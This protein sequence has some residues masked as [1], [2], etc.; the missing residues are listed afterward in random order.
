MSRGEEYVSEA[1]AALKGAYEEPHSLA[2]YVDKVFERPRIASHA[3]KYLV[4]AIE[5]QGTRSVIE[6]GEE[7][8]R[9]RFFDDPHNDGEHAV[10]GNTEVLNAFVD[11]LRTIAAER[12]KGE[13]IIWF[14]GPTATGKSE[15]KRCLINGL[16]E[17]SKTEKGRRYTV[18]WNVEGAADTRGLSYGSEQHSDEDDWYESPVQAHPLSVFPDEV[19][20]EILGSINDSSDDHVDLHVDAR[21]D[22]FSREAYDYLEE[23]YRRNGDAEELFSAITDPGH[24][25]VKNYVVDVGQGIGV[26]HSEDE[27]HPKQ[28]L[29]GSWMQGMLQELD[30]RG[31]KNPQAFSYD[32]VLSQGNGL[33]TIVEDAAQHADLLQ[34]LLNVPDER[35]VKLDKG[36]G[37]DIDTQMLIISNPDLEDQL[38]QHADR[39]GTDPLKALKRRLDKHEFTYL[40]N[41]SLETELIRRELTGET[42]VWETEE[43][44]ELEA[45]IREPISMKVRGSDGEI[46]ERELAPHTIEAAAMYAVVT[47]LEDGDLPAGIDLVD[48]AVLYDKGY[49]QDGDERRDESEFEFDDET[50]GEQGIPVTFT[51]D[52]LAELLQIETDRHHAELPVERVVMPRDVLNAMAEGL[53]GAPMFSAG[54]RAEF[55]NRVVPVKN[56]LFGQQESDV[57]EAIL[58]DN[59]VDEETVGEYVEHVYAWATDERITNDRGERIEPDPLKMKLFEVEHMGRFAERD[60]E[61]KKPSTAVAE[62][63]RSKIITSLNRHAWEHRDEDFS[64]SNVDLTEIPIIRSLLESYDWDDVARIYE[65]FEPNQWDDPPANTETESVKAQ[66]IENMIDLFD[67]TAASAELTSRHVIGQIA[68]KWE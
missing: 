5:S 62:F 27:G 52:V 41:I 10:L 60:Y 38:N 18:E 15:L 34:K 65:D 4:E 28:R 6:E 12:G 66:T 33:L 17:Y 48:K 57:L 26:L 1:D 44:D 19:R 55:E 29:V 16:R 7:K 24:L 32:G 23:Q 31:R 11:D 67:Y 14:D 25:R 20:S 46:W 21:L 43:Y 61:G 9:Y 3:S 8:E 54:E 64:V 40:T 37:M 50:N 36:I 47:R 58:H 22:P 30:S 56:F 2:E 35:T 68:Y 45:K 42:T 53:D 49:L 13:K 51:R 59:R 39:N 63:R